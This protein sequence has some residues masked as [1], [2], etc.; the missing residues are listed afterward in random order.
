MKLASLVALLAAAPAL[1]MMP[2]A[3]YPDR[4]A[5]CTM[6]S[7]AMAAGHTPA[8]AAQGPQGYNI[9]VTPGTVAGTIKVDIKG[10]NALNGLL[11]RIQDSTTKAP[12]GKWTTLPAGVVLKPTDEGNDG[13]TSCGNSVAQQKAGFGTN[14]LSAVWTAPTKTYTGNIQVQAM[15]VTS[16]AGW[17]ITRPV[18]VAFATGTPT[19]DGTT[20]GA[21]DAPI[22]DTPNGGGG[23]LGF[24]DFRV[25][26]IVGGCLVAL[27]V[28]G[29]TARIIIKRRQNAS[30]V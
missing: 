14:S 11:L 4:S 10:T 7:A 25:Y 8:V 3:A 23:K 1:L 19:V 12:V 13:A 2:V 21:G 28:G 20:G 30:A 29:V 24:N 18:A 16:F 5:L 27:I 6:D 22:G 9:T 17:S 26:L 15:L